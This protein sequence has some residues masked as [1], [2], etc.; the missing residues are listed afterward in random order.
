MSVPLTQQ[1]GV[2]GF[3]NPCSSPVESRCPKSIFPSKDRL[4]EFETFWAQATAGRGVEKGI[5]TVAA[6]QG[7]STLPSFQAAQ[8]FWGVL[9]SHHQPQALQKTK[10]KHQKSTA[11][12][13]HA[14]GVVS[15]ALPGT[16]WP[17]TEPTPHSQP[18]QRTLQVAW[19]ISFH[20]RLALDFYFLICFPRFL[21][22]L[23]I[24]SSCPDFLL[25]LEPVQTHLN[26]SSLRGR[27]G[28]SK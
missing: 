23:R 10:H 11:S 7:H 16:R 12:G 4:S 9:S 24:R 14:V 27:P 2:T 1:A 19:V 22:G 20:Q 25:L 6:P 28:T 18:S 26:S 8:A 17:C 15:G 21:Q 5:G 3:N 13:F